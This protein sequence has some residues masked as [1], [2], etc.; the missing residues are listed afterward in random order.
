MKNNKN[1]IIIIVSILLIVGV[2]VFII[3]NRN[4]IFKKIDK[5]VSNT[6]VTTNIN[7][8]INSNIN[9]ITVIEG[10]VEKID[11]AVK[12]YIKMK[13]N[14][15][16]E[17]DKSNLKLLVYDIN[18]NLIMETIIENVEKFAV[19]QERLIEVAANKDLTNASRYV[20]EKVK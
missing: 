18:N 3:L 6:K 5:I 14:T 17:I 16:E 4:N 11:K 20:I 13:N 2:C 19:G 15:N 8:K 12:I 9:E 7:D 10:K 1:K